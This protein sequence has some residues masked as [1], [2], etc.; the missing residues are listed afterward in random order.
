MD[1][2]KILQI[3]IFAV[4]AIIVFRLFYWQFLA[5]TAFV[6]D[7]FLKDSEI[8]AS[9]GEIFASD[10]F[11]LVA[12]QESF[13]IYAKP[14]ELKVKPQDIAKILAPFLI[15]EKFTTDSARLSDSDKDQMKDEI[16][17]KEKELQ[18]KLADRNLFWVQLARKI[19]LE[20]KKKVE[21]KK[22]SGIGFVQDEKR[23]YPEASMAA[24]L[25]GFVAFDKV[26]RDTGY[27]GLEGFWDR[28]LRG[29]VG[30]LGQ[31][32]DPLGL[33]ILVGQYRPILPK[34]GASLYLSIERE[35]QFMVEDKLRKAV[36]KY[37]AKDG[38]VI[39]A[40]PKN[41]K[42][43]AMATIPTYDPALR[44]EFDES[45]YKNPAVADTFEPGSIFKPITMAAALDTK[46]VEPNTKCT[47]CSGPRQVAG[48]EIATWNKKYHP[49]STMTEVIQNSDNVGMTFVAE[50]LGVKNF[51]SYVEKFGFGQKTDI[52]LQEESTGLLRPEDEW[53]EI[54]LFTASFGQGIAIT[55]IQLVQA[56]SSIANHGLLV[57]PKVVTKVADSQSEE[58]IKPER[59]IQVVSP[60]TALQ[61]TEM[62]V[63]AV[64]YGEARFLAPKG[65]RVAGKTGTA[66]IPIAGHYDP[67]KTIASFVG[68]APADDPKFVMLV[69]FSQPSSSPFGSETAAPTFFEIAKELFIHF[70][71][72]SSK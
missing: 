19:R 56:I 53:R 33:P 55:P 67:N 21:E 63:N 69:R 51:L 48:F 59:E 44:G 43:L 40:D 60:K 68:F 28:K 31:E 36:E 11:P 16:K 24:Q 12:N 65:Y 61:V 32:Q 1:R 52:D 18:N 54:D 3:I 29:K 57:S 4:A 8:P 50:K 42:I 25:L 26:G 47:V 58:E 41:G 39:V 72:P 70:G 14:H 38:T 9:R 71:I 7:A 2:L 5:K 30:R 15:S 22:I 64:E 27:F 6:S 46:S 13:L 37:G 45:L 66:Q 20:I 23:F 17:N 34:Q 10:N 49:D 62:M 35:I